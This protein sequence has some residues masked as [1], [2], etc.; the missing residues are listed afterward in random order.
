MIK[1]IYR[2]DC[3]EMLDDDKMRKVETVMATNAI[4]AEVKAKLA[5]IKYD[6]VDVKSKILDIEEDF[7][8]RGIK[9]E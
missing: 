7:F 2:I 9:Y 4:D 6:V 3:Y 5:R 8:K 1:H